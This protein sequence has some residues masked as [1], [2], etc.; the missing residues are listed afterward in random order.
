MAS[1]GECEWFEK[2]LFWCNAPMPICIDPYVV[3][4]T[5]VNEYMGEDCPCFTPKRK[6]TDAGH[7]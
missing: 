3:C 2:R 7:D 5:N 1:C 4:K 6:V